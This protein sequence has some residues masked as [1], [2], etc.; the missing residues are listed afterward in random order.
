MWGSADILAQRVIQLTADGRELQVSCPDR[1]YPKLRHSNL[2]HKC[3]PRCFQI[4]SR[5][6]KA[7]NMS[8]GTQTNTPRGLKLQ[9]YASDVC[10]SISWQGQQRLAQLYSSLLVDGLMEQNE[11]DLWCGPGGGWR[12]ST[13]DEYQTA[14]GTHCRAPPLIKR[15]GRESWWHRGEWWITATS[16]SLVSARLAQP[17]VSQSLPLFCPAQ[18]LQQNYL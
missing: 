2:I 7:W 16:P 8:G 17:A 5:R 4:Y 10:R 12:L 18:G 1:F 11:D 15:E 14:D 3:R 13:W 6:G 9:N